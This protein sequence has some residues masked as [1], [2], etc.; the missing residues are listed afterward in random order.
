ML[1]WT[2]QNL[3]TALLLACLV[4]VACG[5]RRIGPVARHSLWLLVLLK[6]L[7][8]PMV[9]WPWAIRD[10]LAALLRAAPVAAH[11][12]P[13]S[14]P[15][16]D[17]SKAIV[18]PGIIPPHPSTPL[19][20]TT[21]RL[22]EELPPPL[23]V[24]TSR[25][26]DWPATLLRTSTFLWLAG[27]IAFA[28]IHLTRIARMMLV[29]HDGKNADPS[30]A[31][32]ISELSNRLDISPVQTLVTRRIQS[33]LIWCLFRPRMLWPADLPADMSEASMH[34][35]I[36]HEL[37]HLKR[38]DHW[39]G[40]LEL[41]AGCIWWWNP[42]FWYVRHQLRENA[43]L[44]CDAWVVET[45]PKG[46][47]AYAEGLLAVCECMSTTPSK[48]KFRSIAPMPALGVSTG[49]RRFLERRLAMI[50]REHHSLRLPRFGLAMIA[51]LALGTLP[52][53]SQKTVEQPPTATAEAPPPLYRQSRMRLHG[54]NAPVLVEKVDVGLA[55]DVS[56]LPGEATQLLKQYAEK[57]A[58]ARREMEAALA[59]ERES[60]IKQLKQLQDRYTKAGQLDEAVAIRDRVRQLQS[61]EISLEP[62][63][64][65]LLSNPSGSGAPGLGGRSGMPGGSTTPRSLGTDLRSFSG[66]S[67]GGLG[68]GFGNFDGSGRPDESVRAGSSVKTG[69]IG[70]E[71][72]GGLGDAALIPHRAD[73]GNLTAFRDRV[74]QQ[75]LIDVTGQ[76][77]GTIWGTDVYSDDSPLA[78]AVVHAGILQ[79]GQQ[80]LVR[81]TIL[82]GQDAFHGVT[83]NG[84]ESR[85]FGPW[86]GSYR[87]E[88]KPVTDPAPPMRRR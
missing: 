58:A 3:A 35:L 64:I 53:W 88:A 29:V 38:R 13:Q 61:G 22:A 87:I 24:S 30:L 68:A 70:G 36:V 62:N 82:P 5:F 48:Q 72:G 7:A 56:A 1:W 28:A 75:L 32:R 49:G 65:N 57:E 31:R 46:R 66:S 17:A 9:A 73:P 41:I 10:P 80:G 59:G 2:L 39:V 14:T 27:A 33:P 51:L 55:W 26:R 11:I 23:A 63:G 47:R 43:E 45:L 37:A 60:L 4:R 74:G 21:R 8:P 77:D 42:L 84:V 16:H 40:W 12:S 67:G 15:R 54:M 79:P 20:T 19:L 71:G 69:G 44:A 18:D 52:A 78:T 81:V 76:P 50:L 83:R 6:L 25:P 85:D 34:G 86:E